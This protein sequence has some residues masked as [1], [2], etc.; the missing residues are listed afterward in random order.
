MDKK[1]DFAQEVITLNKEVIE[2]NKQLL[3]KNNQ[4]MM[5]NEFMRTVLKCVENHKTVL[6]TVPEGISFLKDFNVIITDTLH[7]MKNM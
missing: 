5:Y 1:I 4:L 7:K 6:S 2:K 3:E